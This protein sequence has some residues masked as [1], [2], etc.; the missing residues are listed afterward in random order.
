MI[1]AL[2]SL[3]D[4]VQQSA[5]HAWL[6]IPSALLL[7]ALHGLEP[8]HSKTM[9]AA[10]IVA[11]RGTIPQAALLAICATI[12]HTAVIWIL[13]PFV[14]KF[15]QSFRAEATEPYFQ[16]ASGAIITGIAV[17]MIVRMHRERRAAADHHHAPAGD[18]P[19]GG[20]M[21]DTGH[22][23]CEISILRRVCRHASDFISTIARDG[24]RRFSWQTKFRSRR[25]GR[26][27]RSSS[28]RSSKKGEFLESTTDIPEPHEFAVTLTLSHGDHAHTYQT[29]FTEDEHHHH[30]DY[31]AADEDFE[32]AHQRAHAQEIQK[33]FA[34]RNVTTGQLALFGLTGG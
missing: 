30:H 25:C 19:H 4:L 29:Q 26:T 10:F 18:G 12:S 17:W 16:I 22:G 20:I 24:R 11:V 13:A 5:A 15:G 21:M 27:V 9:M 8:G 1:F 32:D 14:L 2:T 31:I 3:P 34:N 6:F 7:G 23:R 33:R 28:S